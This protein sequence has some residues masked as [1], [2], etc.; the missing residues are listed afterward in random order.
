MTTSITTLSITTSGIVLSVVDAE[1][2]V[3]K[4]FLPNVVL[5]S[6]ID[7]KCHLLKFFM[8]NVVLLSVVQLSVIILK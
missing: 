6:V 5:L 4:L 2:H 3:L 8:L 1:C 7:A